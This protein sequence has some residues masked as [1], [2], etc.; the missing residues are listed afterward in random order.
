MN[1]TENSYQNE[2][3]DIDALTSDFADI[4]KQIQEL[5]IKIRERKGNMAV[6]E[7]TTIPS[8]LQKQPVVVPPLNLK[9]VNP[10]NKKNVVDSRILLNSAREKFKNFDPERNVFD[11]NDLHLLANIVANRHD[12]V[13][14]YLTLD[15]KKKIKG[16]AESRLKFLNKNPKVNQS[17]IDFLKDA[18]HGEYQEY[19]HRD[20]V[21][22]FSPVPTDGS[23]SVS[24]LPTPKSRSNSPMSTGRSTSS[25][26]SSTPR[27]QVREAWKGG[28]KTRKRKQRITKRR[29]T[30]KKSHKK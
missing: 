7:T 5:Q 24:P 11:K 26:P 3:K 29:R 25:S 18:L 15:Q 21:I 22:P 2:K 6:E 1:S 8:S 12:E 13:Q 16:F 4:R 23:I 9:E 19:K 27:R 30:N 17:E 10:G 20:D 28:K 14:D